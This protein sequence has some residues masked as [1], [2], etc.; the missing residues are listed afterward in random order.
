MYHVA[1][2]H[3]GIICRTR[4][5]VNVIASFKAPV[6][7][8]VFLYQCLLFAYS[9]TP[10]KFHLPFSNPRARKVLGRNVSYYLNQAPLNVANWI[11][12][13]PSPSLWNIHPFTD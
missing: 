9:S 12:Y 3:L 2:V 6:E 5:E 10:L 13:H 7:C 8:S 4:R 1:L 11:E